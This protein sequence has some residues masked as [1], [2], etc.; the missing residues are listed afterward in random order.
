MNFKLPSVLQPLKGKDCLSLAEFSPE[1]VTALVEYAYQLKKGRQDGSLPP[2][3]AGKG[4]ALIFDKAST[5]TRVSF[6]TGMNLLGGFAMTFNQNDLQ[7]GRGESIE[8]TG[9]TLSRYINGIMVRISD[10][11]MVERLAEAAS[12]P[13]ISG[14]T[15]MYHPCQ[16]LADLLTLYEKDQTLHGKKLAYVGDG[17]NVLHSLLLGC[18]AVGISVHVSTPVGYEPSL[19]VWKKAEQ[20]AAQSGATL[21]WTDQPAEAVAGADAV[22]TDVWASMGQEAEKEKRQQD[23][24]DYQIDQT[25]LKQAKPDALFMHCLPAY[26]GIEVTAEV[27]DG[28]QSVVY[29]QAE[30][31]LHAQNAILVAL[32]A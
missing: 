9:A 18:A 11:K 2:L 22:Y 31:R 13:V 16:T 28:L 19:S 1:Q 10:Q 7:L 17:N 32:L 30:N 4:L 24:A 20:I 14:L 5:R 21:A 6:E 29:D 23:F 3:L 8:D 12:V 26:R 27:I 25:L 15:D